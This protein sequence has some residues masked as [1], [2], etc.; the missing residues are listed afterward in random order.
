M[1]CL[2]AS[3]LAWGLLPLGEDP[4]GPGPSAVTVPNLPSESTITTAAVAAET[5]APE[6]LSIK[7][8]S[9]SWPKTLCTP[10]WWPMMILLLAVVIPD[11]ASVP[12][13]T[14]LLV[15]SLFISARL[16]MAV[17]LFPL[18]LAVSPSEPMAVLESPV[19]LF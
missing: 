19:V 8:L 17:L 14:L 4:P 15:V 11:P 12:T 2:A 13:H 6:I 5:G 7:H 16:P 18:V 3:G 10:E 1:A 9:L